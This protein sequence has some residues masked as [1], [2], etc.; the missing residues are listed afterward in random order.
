MKNKMK[1]AGYIKTWRM[2]F[3]AAT[4]LIPLAHTAYA[5]P[6]R[7]H[8]NQMERIADALQ[9]TDEQHQQLKQIHRSERN[10]RMSLHDAMQDN[11][12][13]LEKLNPSARSYEEKLVKLAREEARLVK[14]KVIQEGKVRARVYAILTPEQREKA[15]EMK[16]HH[17]RKHRWG[18][19]REFHPR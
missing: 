12:E 18:G 9:L 4:C 17:P 1:K 3:L 2:L 8:G 5:E 7:P 13:A 14:R 10:E 11:H 15:A 16:K 6:E 19:E